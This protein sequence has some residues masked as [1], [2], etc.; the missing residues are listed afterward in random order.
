LPQRHP[1]YSTVTIKLPLGDFTPAQGRGIAALAR[2]FTGETLRTTVEQNLVLRWVSN[3]DLQAVHAALRELD[4]AEVG[5][6]KI[7]DVTSC[8][9]TD[10][11]K[12]GTSSSRGLARELRR[13]LQRYED[14]MPDAVR[15]LH[16]KCSGCFNSCGQHHV[17]DIGFLGVSRNV[18]GR[19]VPHFQLVVGGA[20][21]GNASE[22]GLAIGAIPSKRVPEAVQLLADAYTAEREVNETF[23]GWVHRVG[24]RH[25]KELVAGLTDV[26]TFEAAPE[27]YRDWGDPR[28]FTIGD[29]GVGECAGAVISPSQFAFAESERLIFEAQLMLD[30]SKAALASENALAAMFS[31]A[32]AVCFEF[33]PQLGNDRGKIAECFDRKL[34]ETGLFDAASPGGRFSRHF[35]RARQAEVADVTIAE[36]RQRVE[37][38]QLF[39]DAA[40]AYD[41][42][43]LA[44]RVAAPVQVNPA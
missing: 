25:V 30:E 1:G 41:S 36:A 28:V 44:A 43:N 40:H 20:W 21:E 14:R 2:R 8:P 22:F 11:C 34:G 38:A 7:S 15:G 9:G 13:S 32:A 23:R 35:V 4:L 26:P 12:L 5:P 33:E 6:S 39:I 17:A 37:E 24:R 42:K 3:S 16:V 31:A 29:I 27:M 19:R 10:T 18:S